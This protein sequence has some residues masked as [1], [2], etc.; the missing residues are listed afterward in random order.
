MDSI[1]TALPSKLDRLRGGG[2]ARLA[3]GDRGRRTLPIASPR[4]AAD[5]VAVPLAE[6]AMIAVSA[7]LATPLL[8]RVLAG[9]GAVQ[10]VADRAAGRSLAGGQ[11]LAFRLRLGVG[12]LIVKDVGPKPGVRGLRRLRALRRAGAAENL[13]RALLRRPERGRR[14]AARRHLLLRGVAPVRRHKVRQL[15]RQYLARRRRPR[16]RHV[17]PQQAAARRRPIHGVAPRRRHSSAGRAHLLLMV[18]G[19]GGRRGSRDLTGLADV[20]RRIGGQHVGSV[21]AP[22]AVGLGRSAGLDLRAGRPGVRGDRRRRAGDA[23]MR[24]LVQGAALTGAS[25]HTRVEDH[26]VGSRHRF[27]W[28]L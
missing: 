20:R 14:R 28:L 6:V 8:Q 25:L 13:L 12:A 19:R 16:G 9:V 5:D 27:F 11:S 21:R 1:R 17:A 24:H 23:P 10:G 4:P 26:H 22:R 3:R 7:I 15:E 18:E 2:L